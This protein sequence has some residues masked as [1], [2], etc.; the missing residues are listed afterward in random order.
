MIVLAA[1]GL[2]W[3]LTK[4]SFHFNLWLL[5]ALGVVGCIV[6]ILGVWLLQ[7][8]TLLAR[9][10]FGRS[11][12]A[13]AA[14]VWVIL[15]D[16]KIALIVMLSS[17]LAQI[18]ICTTVWAIGIAIGARL[19]WIDALIVMPGVF[20]LTALPISIAGWGVREGTMLF[21]LGLFGVSRGGAVT[22][23][24]LFGLVCLA[25]ASPA[26]SPGC[27]SAIATRVTL[28]KICRA[29]HFPKRPVRPPSVATLRE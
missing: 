24:V 5:E 10:R 7:R 3:L 14:D 6:A 23:S 11:V 26:A 16:P 22:I 28:R 8:S 15:A 1:M 19:S 17:L 13:A 21:V 25:S 27:F 18:L 4:A 20:I 2:P 29:N 12:H 9:N